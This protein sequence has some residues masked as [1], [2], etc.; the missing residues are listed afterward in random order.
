MSMPA[1][2]AMSGFTAGSLMLAYSCVSTYYSG[3]LIGA[4][5]KRF[6]EAD[7]YPKLFGLSVKKG[8]LHTA[9]SKQAARWGEAAVFACVLLQVRRPLHSLPCPLLFQSLREEKKTRKGPEEASK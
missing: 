1:T 4:L 8:M 5:C 9:S 6:P 7:S 3:E 2:M